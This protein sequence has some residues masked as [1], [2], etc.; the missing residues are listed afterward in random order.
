MK[1]KSTSIFL[2]SHSPEKLIATNAYAKESIQQ[3]LDNLK[4]EAAK[5]TPAFTIFI[6]QEGDLY[7][8]TSTIPELAWEMLEYAQEPLNILYPKSKYNISLSQENYISVR[9]VN[10]DKLTQLVR[11]NGV[12]ITF[13]YHL[14]K[15]EHNLKIDEEINCQEK[16]SSYTS[17]KTM[18]LFEDDS[19]TFLP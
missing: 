19:F 8:F 14:L 7:H 11:K 16:N 17:V 12:L 13:P 9:L 4:P 3:I 15:K 6:N 18:K 2:L 5:H 10:T 1:V